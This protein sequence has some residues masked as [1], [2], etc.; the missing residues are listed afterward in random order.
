MELELF[1]LDSDHTVDEGKTKVRLFCKDK[2]LRNVVVIV[3]DFPA[4]FYVE[5]AG[6]V[7]ELKNKIESFDFGDAGKVIGVEVVEKEFLGKPKELLKV[8]VDDYRNIM[9]IRNIVKEWEEVKEEYEYAI[10]F[11]QRFLID[12]QI[13]PMGW[14]KVKGKEVKRSGYERVDL[15][16][17]ADEI[18]PLEKDDELELKTVAFDIEV[19]EEEEKETIIMISVVSKDFK[20]VLTT[21][22]LS[23]SVDFVEV[24]PTETAMIK[25]FMEIVNE[26]DPD[27]IVGYNTDRFDMIKLRERCEELKI[28]F[29]LGRSKE[30]VKLV[31][32]GRVSSARVKGRVHIDLYDFV[33]HILAPTLKTEVLSL[34]AVAQEIVGIGKLDVK[35]KE[36]EESWKEKKDLERIAEYCLRDSEITY[37]LAEQLLPQII[38]ISRL[39]GLIPFDASRY[40]YSQ[41]DEHYL[42]R[43]AVASN[44]LIPNRP[45]TEE[46]QK[47]RMLP[48]YKGAIVIEPKKGIHPDI[49]VFDFRSLYPTIIVTHNVSPD[50]INCDHEEC[51]KNKPEDVDVYFCMKRTGFIPKNL[52]EIIQKRTEIKKRMKSLDKNSLEYRRLYNMQYALKIIANSTYGY[53]GYVGARWFCYKCAEATAAWGRHYIKKIIAIAKSEGCEIIYGDTDSI[54]IRIPNIPK[55]KLLSRASQ[56]LEKINSSLPGIIELEFR[57]LYEGGIFVTVKGEKRGAKK[58]YALIDEKGNLEIRGFETVRRDWCDLAKWLQH[59]VLRIILQERDPKKAVE[60]VRKTIQRVKEGKATKDELTIYT[61]LTMPLSQY[62]AMGPHV[63]TAMKMKQRGRPVGEGMI[64]RYIIVKGSGSIS[65][66]AEPA[67]DVEEGDYDPDYY[68]NHQILP[69]AMRVLKAIGYTE[70]DVLS[71]KIQKSLDAWFQ[72]K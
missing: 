67:D 63:K 29:V 45:K 26:L 30:K 1:L 25:R 38:A 57:G 31:R 58:R 35:W 15:I 34:D 52:K 2:S 47:R 14:I 71:G 24:L 48:V 69:A 3:K 49:I 27:F 18:K 11:Y 12:K 56:L 40:T 43:K 62:K 65:D 39:T 60:V 42:M 66:R 44:I 36:I 16:V 46:I 50:T 37:L 70:Q 41:L 19:V 32:R 13:T 5:P 21:E 59:E 8:Y 33:E 22:P 23:K 55:E 17:E 6:D 61:Q 64:I 51:K 9:D 68:I 20:K 72:R 4:Y 54:F 53:M 7:K 28:D 10:S